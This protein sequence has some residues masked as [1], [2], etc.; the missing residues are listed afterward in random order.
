MNIIDVMR[1]NSIAWHTAS[2][3][4]KKRLERENQVLGKKLDASY[5]AN[6]GTWS[7]DSQRLYTLEDAP[8]KK[9][10]ENESIKY[11]FGNLDYNT[12]RDTASG[13]GGGFS[14]RGDEEPRDNKTFA[15]MMEEAREYLEEK[16]DEIGD[17]LDIGDKLKKFGIGALIVLFIVA[18]IK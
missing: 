5:D 3:E 15:D 18:L 13:G 4:E 17:S 6:T 7:K 9:E 8:E 1:E 12:T 14:G 10:R 11:L 2:A 16:A